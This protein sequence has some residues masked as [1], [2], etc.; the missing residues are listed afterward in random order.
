MKSPRSIAAAFA[1]GLLF[2]LGLIVAGM[3]NPAK[4]LDFLDLAGHWD[5]SLAFVMAGGIAAMA[6]AYALL[7]RRRKCSLLGEPMQVPVSRVIDRRLLAGSALFGIGWGLAGIC[8]G[9]SLVLLGQG[10]ASAFIFFAAMLAGM[11]VFEFIER[12]RLPAKA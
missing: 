3:S 2:G 7:A 11:G 9:P 6:P 1:T 10:S 12:R 4:V 8:P 5:P